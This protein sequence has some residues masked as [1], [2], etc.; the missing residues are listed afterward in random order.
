[1]EYCAQ[2]G[3]V[4]AIFAMLAISMDLVAGHTGMVTLA[5]AG[6]YGVGAYVSALLTIHA[7]CGFLFASVIAM[8]SATGLSMVLSALTL[9][10]SE[11]EF[12]IATFAFQMV[13][14]GVF[15]SW[16]TVTNGS[17]GVRAIPRPTIL[18]WTIDSSGGMFILAGVLLLGECLLIWKLTVSPFGRVLHLIREDTLLASALGKNVLYYKVV[19][20]GISAAFAAL[21]GSI[22]AH[23]VTY[24]D[25]S[26]FSVMDSILILS[27]VII[28]G[29]GSYTGPIVGAIVLATLPEVLRFIGLPS[30]VGANLRQ[31]IYGSLMVI[32]I[33]FRPKGLTG[34][35]SFGRRSEI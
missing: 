31:V 14:S 21:A 1:M 11:D 20:F 22:F 13:L 8:L 34:R 6:F 15:N 10:V 23:Y 35:F 26:S 33:V 16:T 17:L 25:P 19:A 29:M 7:G 18:L 28:G 2:I 27:M 12:V 9:R 5:H 4:V 3:I 24:I 30:S 32:V